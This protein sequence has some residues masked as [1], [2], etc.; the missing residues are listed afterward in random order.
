MEHVRNRTEQARAAEAREEGSDASVL[1]V[2]AGVPATPQRRADAHGVRGDTLSEAGLVDRALA[3]YEQAA[4]LGKKAKWRRRVADA[5]FALGMP[6]QA[7]DAYKRAIRLDPADPESHFYLAEFLRVMG[8]TYWAIDEFREASRLAPDRGYYALRLGEASLAVGFVENAVDALRRAVRAKPRDAYFRFR[9][10]NALIRARSL[11]AAVREL[12]RAT[13]LAPCDDYYYAL[14]AVACRAAGKSD[15]ALAALL[16]AGRIR[17]KNHAYQYLVA[18]AY[19]EAGL[20]SL[21]DHYTALAGELDS[22]DADYVDRLRRKV[23][24]GE[25]WRRPAWT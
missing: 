15:E 21:A 8:R 14:L 4:R 3:D 23:L 17:P 13:A 20:T 22:Y 2:L 12:K 11:S 9:L 18:E 10:A 24:T 5:Y 1:G 16:Q 25:E 6:K 19:R 7:Y